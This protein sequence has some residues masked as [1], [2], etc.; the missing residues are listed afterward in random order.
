MLNK[1]LKER[2]NYSPGHAPKL[3]ATLSSVSPT[4]LVSQSSPPRSGA[5]LV[6]VLVLVRTP[7]PQPAEQGPS[8][9]ADH[10]PCT[11]FLYLKK[12]FFFILR[13]AECLQNYSRG[14]S[15]WQRYS[16]LVPHRKSLIKRWR[17]WCIGMKK[18]QFNAPFLLVI[19]QKKIT[20]SLRH[21]FPAGS[22][23]FSMVRSNQDPGAWNVLPSLHLS[24]PAHPEAPLHRSRLGF[25]R[26]SHTLLSLAHLS[27]CV[28]Q[29]LITA[30]L[31]YVERSDLFPFF[32][33]ADCREVIC[34]EW[35]F[36]GFFLGGGWIREIPA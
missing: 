28:F 20:P 1:S 3:Q 19:F 8:D 32:S 17:F 34:E 22:T 6:Q 27:V 33:C 26:P 2:L 18:N 4:G 16:K 35:H 12:L 7:G 15:Y 11:A 31:T 13:N 36:K 10:P 23:M 9:Q 30:N 24:F 5:G 25:F 29:D 21:F 14:H